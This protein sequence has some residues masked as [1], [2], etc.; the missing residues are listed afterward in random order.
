MYLILTNGHSATRWITK[1]LSKD[2]FSKCYHS[3]SLLKI[4]P[5]INDIISYHKFLKEHNSIEKLIVGS[6]HIPFNLN[7]HFL[8][9]LNKL[10]IKTFWLI[11]NPIDK[12]NSM[13]QFYLE[14]FVLSGFFVK[15][16]N[17]IIIDNKNS[18]IFVDKIF[19]E[20]NEQININFE[21]YHNSKNKYYLS[22]AFDSL[23]F[24]IN[25]KV[26]NL[27]LNEILLKDKN[28][29][30]YIS[31]VIINLFLFT[32]GSCLRF[33]EQVVNFDQNRV[34]LFEEIIQSKEKFL[35]FAKLLNN[36]FDAKNLNF[37][38]FF[39]KIGKN[40]NSYEKTSFWPETFKE[41]LFKKIKDKNLYS[42]YAKMKYEIN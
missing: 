8:E 29:K 41:H 32:S 39:I 13:M 1:I 2:K 10:E 22:Y 7:D 24:K 15:K 14:K 17:P 16:K 19:N 5:K 20:C 4:N 6:I 31:K 18:K 25:K 36:K 12:I 27:E 38:D 11:R 21:K 34:V 9:E 26:L 33:D 37:D 3:D 30:Q 35:N 28:Y 40:A 23:K 42:F